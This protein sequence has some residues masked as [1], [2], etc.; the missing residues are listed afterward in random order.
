M[1][2]PMSGRT[3]LN[4]AGFRAS[5]SI[6]PSA[7]TR[8]GVADV[9]GFAGSPAQ[10]LRAK[11]WDQFRAKNSQYDEVAGHRR[12]RRGQRALPSWSIF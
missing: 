12:F 2:G 6:R 1:S 9:M 7:A 10:V 3:T 5:L 11:G 8:P 4:S